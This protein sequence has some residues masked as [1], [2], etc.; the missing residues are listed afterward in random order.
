[1]PSLFVTYVDGGGVWS[2][3]YKI[4]FPSGNYTALSLARELVNTMNGSTNFL[5]N[6]WVGEAGPPDTRVYRLYKKLNGA[7][8]PQLSNPFLQSA[9][10]LTIKASLDRTRIRYHI[11]QNSDASAVNT[12]SFGWGDATDTTAQDLFGFRVDFPTP[13]IPYSADG[14]KFVSSDN[15]GKLSGYA[16]LV[17]EFT[18]TS[19]Y[20]I[21]PLYRSKISVTILIQILENTKYCFSASHAR[22][23]RRAAVNSSKR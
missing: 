15:S 22:A 14:T 2:N 11:W 5:V 9:T 7:W 12:I 23:A 21:F 16:R 8:E 18:C 13:N 6:P 4:V 19:G 1:M 17:Y 10:P 20:F 3:D